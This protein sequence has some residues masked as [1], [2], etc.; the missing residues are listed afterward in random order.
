M[1]SSA[2]SSPAQSKSLRGAPLVGSLFEF[3]NHRLALQLRIARECGDLG[4]FRIGPIP[5]YAVSSAELAHQVLV[6]HADAFV[7]SRGLGKIARPM[8]GDGLLT[9][10]HEKHRR[11]RKL[12]APAFTH[13][14]IAAYAGAMAEL[15]ERAQ[16]RLPDGAVVDVA[17]EM[18][19]LTLAIVGKT[20][21]DTDVS[22]EADDVGAA[23]TAANH[24]VSEA[25]TRLPS[26]LWLPT[27]KNRDARRAIATIDAIIYRLIAA[28]RAAA[29]DLGDVLS[30]LVLA[31]DEETGEGMSDQQIRDEAVTLFLAGHET[32][33]N[34][35]AWSFH[36]LARHPDVYDRLAT[37]SRALLAGRTPTMEDLPRLPLAAMVL[38]ETMR[39]YPPAYMVGRQA[40]RDVPLG[41]ITLRRGDT[42]F[43]NLY[44]M[45]RRAD[46]FDAPDEFRPER[47]APEREKLLP[48]GAYLPFG[49]GPRVCIGNHF[50]L[51]EGQLILA[52]LAQ[53]LTF[54][55]D[56][57]DIEPE[58]LVTLRPKGGLPVRV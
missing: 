7:K 32:T 31:R 19:R 18:M 49:A 34:A 8:L 5:I 56:G 20:L 33:A 45:H 25:V 17:H 1:G 44:A 13:R 27:R 53:K 46:I 57:A 58:P 43:V 37:E 30:T 47:F 11:Q 40:E 52:H 36:L 10:E 9:S 29:V 4:R 28:R 6:E 24:Y 23:I 21:F 50:A 54:H 55:Y 38:K 12:I 3:R 14:R 26:P 16:A 35:L 41:G 2:Q 22:D 51:M 39:L 48:R 42:L 15:A